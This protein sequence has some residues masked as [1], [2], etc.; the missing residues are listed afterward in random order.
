MVWLRIDD[1]FSRHPKVTALSFRE[2]W[3]WLDV[4]CYCASYQTGG[5][6][7]EGLGSIVPGASAKFIGRCGELGLVNVVGGRLRVHDWHVY[8]GTIGERV[9]HF[10]TENPDASANDV[11]KAVGGNRDLVLAEV[12]KL[13][14]GGTGGTGESGSGGTRKPG[15]KTGTE[16]GSESGSYARGPQPLENS[17]KAVMGS[18]PDAHPDADERPGLSHI[19]TIIDEA[20]KEAS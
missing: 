2:R 10:L 1:G 8:N 3:V 11:H 12:R 6:L 7:P 4:L 14:E 17:P 5:Y 19:G 15:T 16:S 9:E 18:R 20:L 13:R